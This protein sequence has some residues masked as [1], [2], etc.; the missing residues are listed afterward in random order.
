ML[1][2]LAAFL[3]GPLSQIS[4]DLKDAYTAK[5]NA[6]NDSERV[7]AE[8]R[9]SI[10]ESR[11]SI[12]LAAQSDPFERWVRPLFALPFIIYNMKLIIWDKV[13][14]LGVT[15]SLSPELYNVQLTV[16]G[17]YFLYEGLKVLKR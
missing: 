14:G 2:F 16:L 1:K 10:L 11:K 9:I 8:G 4:S 7:A 13:F 5:L 17:G 15:D 3:S 12:I 6:K